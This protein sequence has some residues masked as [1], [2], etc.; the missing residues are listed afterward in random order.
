MPIFAGV[1][2]NNS[3]IPAIFPISML[4]NDDSALVGDLPVH[5]S[6]KI[7]TSL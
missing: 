1:A 7:D 2:Q 5:D 3:G 4:Y 6:K